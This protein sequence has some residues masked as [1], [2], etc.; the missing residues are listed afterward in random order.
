[1]GY[2]WGFVKTRGNSK[3]V[4]HKDGIT[5]GMPEG[6]QYSSGLGSRDSLLA[7]SAAERVPKVIKV[8]PIGVG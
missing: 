3:V 2:A 1:M 4:T 5:L 8:V 6:S 7:R